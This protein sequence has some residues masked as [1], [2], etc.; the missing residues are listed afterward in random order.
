M[1]TTI[2]R[3]VLANAK[4]AMIHSGGTPWGQSVSFDADTWSAVLGVVRALERGEE[5]VVRDESN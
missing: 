5:I 3:K 1:A 4:H 2:S